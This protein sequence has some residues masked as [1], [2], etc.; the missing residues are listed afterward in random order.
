MNAIRLSSVL[1][2][3]IQQN[4]AVFLWGAPGIGKSAI[5]KQVAERHGMPVVDLRASLLDSTD[6]R[7]IPVVEGGKAVWCPPAFLPQKEDK[8]GILF[9]DELNAAPPLVQAAMYQLVLD[10]RIGEYVLPE[11]WK[12]IAAGNRQ[13][14]RAVVFRLSSA[15]SNRF[16]HITLDADMQSWREWAVKAEIHPLV[17]GF[18]HYKP[19][20]LWHVTENE[21]AFASPRSWEILSDTIKVF[22][23]PTELHDFA[24]GIVGSGP[25]TEF[26]AFVNDSMSAEELKKILTD[27]ENAPLPKRLDR[28]WT[29]VS[30]LSV[31]ET[32]KVNLDAIGAL[33]TRLT[34]EMSLILVKN[35]LQHVPSF[36]RHPQCVSF[37]KAHASWFF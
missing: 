14:D 37:V 34:P 27:P 24:S 35:V 6:L 12:I 32:A 25:A 21:T 31:A 33:L 29:L 20:L 7:G 5:V 1:D 36:M 17:L 10:R 26:M 13:T 11:G 30:Y 9:L 16:I 28:L 15:L 18:L 19:A 22:D 4:W 8:P 23:N 3:L 2:L